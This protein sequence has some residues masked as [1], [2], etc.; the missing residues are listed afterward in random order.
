MVWSHPVKTLRSVMTSI[1]V[2]VNGDGPLANEVME[3]T[4]IN[5]VVVLTGSGPVPRELSTQG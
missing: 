4:I 5:G 2:D 1:L 3:A